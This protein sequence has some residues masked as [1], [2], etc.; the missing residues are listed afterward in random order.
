M[1]ALLGAV[2]RYPWSSRTAIRSG[3]D[4]GAGFII[5]SLNNVISGTSY[6]TP[7]EEPATPGRPGS[8]FRVGESN[9]PD[10]T[11]GFPRRRE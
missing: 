8:L 10:A 6:T 1:I 4:A 11:P 9:A 3:R 7:L 2:D 5:P